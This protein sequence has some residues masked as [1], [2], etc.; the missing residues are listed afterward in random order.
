MRNAFVPHSMCETL[1]SHQWNGGIGVDLETQLINYICRRLISC[2]R[3]NPHEVLFHLRDLHFRQL[4]SF[5]KLGQIN[6]GI[7]L[8]RCKHDTY[9]AADILYVTFHQN[10]EARPFVQPC[11][12]GERAVSSYVSRT[13]S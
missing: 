4:C 3:P 11:A 2:T 6:N 5:S 12:A 1:W 13:R 10:R 7:A 8:H 9:S